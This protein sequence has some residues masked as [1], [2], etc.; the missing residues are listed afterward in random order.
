[1][2]N[3]QITLDELHQRFENFNDDEVLLDVRS[4]QEYALGHIPGSLNIS[5]LLVPVQIEKLKKYKAIYIFCQS[6]GRAQMAFRMLSGNGFDNLVCIS[7]AG[8]GAW[9]SRGYSITN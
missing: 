7:D 5:H 9:A 4:E 6:G 1:M 3:S 2:A 8:V